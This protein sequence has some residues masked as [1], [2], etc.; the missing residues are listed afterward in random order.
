[1]P[2]WACSFLFLS[3]S[4]SLSLFLFFFLVADTQLYKRLCPSVHLS[5]G[6]SVRERKLKSGKTSVLEA[7]WVCVYVGMGVGSGVRSR[8][9]LAGPAHASARF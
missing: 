4:L 1:M 8:W 7:F 3:L 5:V 2:A 9:G 6:P